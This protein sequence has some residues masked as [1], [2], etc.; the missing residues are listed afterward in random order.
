MAKYGFPMQHLAIGPEKQAA[1]YGVYEGKTNIAVK[2][3]TLPP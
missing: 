3:Y 2:M 1:I